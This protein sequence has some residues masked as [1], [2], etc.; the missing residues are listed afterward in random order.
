[1]AI[2]PLSLPESVR[3]PTRLGK[4]LMGFPFLGPD[5]LAWRR[6]RRE[7][8]RRADDCM[9][10]WKNDEQT[11][12]VRD[13]ITRILGRALHW[14][15]ASRKFIP[16]D[17]CEILFFVPWDWDGMDHAEVLLNMEDEY[18]VELHGDT[19]SGMTLGEFVEMI[20]EKRRAE[21]AKA[22]DS[23]TATTSSRRTHCPPW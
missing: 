8:G 3:H 16:E 19:L 2:E 5:R 1:M 9:T 17:P 15:R 23:I 18:G 22:R 13:E 10:L 4:F 6:F 12:R 7:V 20:A 21:P 11:R 14:G